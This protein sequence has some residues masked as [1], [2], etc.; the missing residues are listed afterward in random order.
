MNCAELATRRGLSYCE[1]L[2]VS[3][4]G[5]RLRIPEGDERQLRQL[6]SYLQRAEH[7]DDPNWGA[8]V[9]HAWCLDN[10]GRVVDITWPQR[11]TGSCRYFGVVVPR[12][13]AV[14]VARELNGQEA[15]DWFSWNQA[16][17]DDA[18]G[19]VLDDRYREWPILKHPFTEV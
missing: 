4:A 5:V 7:W 2:A 10:R 3:S 18:G 15:V 13:L 16:N 14:E 11:F 19:G 17:L 1:G 12:A 9:P 8:P 6:V